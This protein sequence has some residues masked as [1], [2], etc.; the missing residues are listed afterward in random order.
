MVHTLSHDT[1]ADIYAKGFLNKTLFRRLKALTNLY[2]QEELDKGWLNPPA[3]NVKGAERPVDNTRGLTHA[4][5]N[6]SSGHELRQ[7]EQKAYKAKD[8]G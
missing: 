3:L 4:V 7:V 6:Y 2:T 8:Q 5:C 1:F